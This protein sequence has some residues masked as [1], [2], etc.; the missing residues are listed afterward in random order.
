LLCPGDPIG[1]A[2]WPGRRHAGGMGPRP[3]KVRMQRYIGWGLACAAIAAEA[4]RENVKP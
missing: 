1:A 2:G 4:A 3:G